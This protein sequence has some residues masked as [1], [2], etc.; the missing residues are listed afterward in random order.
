MIARAVMVATFVFWTETAMGAIAF[1]ALLQVTGAEWPGPL[2]P[3]AERFRMPLLASCLAS[4][5]VLIG[6]PGGFWWRDSIALVAVFAFGIG[7]CRASAA[8]AQTRSRSPRVTQ[9]AV[10]FLVLYAYGS[11]LLAIDWAMSFEPTWTS[12]LFPAYLSIAGLYTGI[13]ATIVVA[14]WRLPASALD[15]A[16]SNDGGR[17]LLGFGLLWMYLVWSQYLVVWYGNLTGE[18]AYLLHRI[19]GEW[20]GLMW[21]VI[22]AR[23]VAPFAVC[24]FRAG[25]RRMPVTVVSIV[26]LAGFWLEC[27]LLIGP[28]LL[29]R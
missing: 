6:T 15:D 21:I 29:T 10:A 12:T 2:R 3:Q 11:G 28:S 9:R 23:L 7:F 22:G 16:R 26:I 5:L 18:I 4:P 8:D 13:A 19:S 14:A 25:R 24:L 17:L 27:L 1:A 20:R